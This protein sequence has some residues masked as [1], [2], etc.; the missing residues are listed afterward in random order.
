MLMLLRQNLRLLVQKL[1]LNKLDFD[2]RT[3]LDFI[4]FFIGVGL[5]IVQPL[6]VHNMD[7]GFIEGGIANA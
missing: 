4:F 6:F 7:T 2:F 3:V 1:R 5:F